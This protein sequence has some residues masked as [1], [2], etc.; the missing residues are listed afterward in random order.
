MKYPEKYLWEEGTTQPENTT[1]VECEI[2][3]RKFAIPNDELEKM[4]AKICDNEACVKAANDQAAEQ[5]KNLMKA[6]TSDDVK[7]ALGD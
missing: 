4:T 7:K 3:H 6:N 1:I 5:I 2:C